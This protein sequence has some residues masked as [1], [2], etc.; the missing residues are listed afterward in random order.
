MTSV[1]SFP[2]R[3]NWATHDAKW[4]GNWSPYI[5]RNIRLAEAPSHGEPILIYE[6]SSKGAEAYMSLAEEFLDRNKIKYNP[7]TKETKIKL[8]E[9][10]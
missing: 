8:R 4:R 2:N 9:V 5:P 7:I 10:K 6:P 3:G 1:W